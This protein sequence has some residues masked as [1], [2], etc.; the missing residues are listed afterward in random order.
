MY[1]DGS[2]SQDGVGLGEV[3]GNNLENHQWRALPIEA[4]IFTAELQTIKSA[5]SII[6][7]SNNQKW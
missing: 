6:K 2:K 7:T 5:L 3:Y 1:T 4:T